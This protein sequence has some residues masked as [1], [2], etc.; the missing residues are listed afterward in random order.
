MAK[1]SQKSKKENKNC[2]L[3][4]IIKNIL[5]QHK[6]KKSSLHPELS[7]LKFNLIKG[8][9][10][11]KKALVKILNKIQL[12]CSQKNHKNSKNLSNK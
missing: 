4:A 5:L 7:K 2:Q 11:K 8:Q 1:I 10:E 3:I 9:T 6:K 12:L